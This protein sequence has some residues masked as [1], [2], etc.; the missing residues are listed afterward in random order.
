MN[1]L[2]GYDISKAEILISCEYVLKVMNRKSKKNVPFIII[3]IQ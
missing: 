2:Y 1:E 3:H